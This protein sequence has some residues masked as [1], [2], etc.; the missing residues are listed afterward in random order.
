MK[1]GMSDFKM[2]HFLPNIRNPILK[3][4]NDQLENSLSNLSDL[5]IADKW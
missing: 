3:K 2:A 5:H 1:K 4:R